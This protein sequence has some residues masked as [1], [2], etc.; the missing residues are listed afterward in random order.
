[1][2][3]SVLLI[4]SKSHQL[5]QKLSSKIFKDKNYWDQLSKEEMQ[6]VLAVEYIKYIVGRTQKDEV[7]S[8]FDLQE[9]YQVR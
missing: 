1:M 9:D 2:S 4:Y 7:E 5:S 6:A 3:L 8:L